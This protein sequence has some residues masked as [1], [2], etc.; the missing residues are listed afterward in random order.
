[1]TAHPKFVAYYR[2]STRAQEQSGLGLAAQQDAVERHVDMT[3]G[4]Q[5]IASHTEIE[6]G[7]NNARPKLAQALA[8]CRKAKAILVIAKLDRLARN[9]AFISG[10][11]DSDVEF[12]ACDMPLA[13]RLTI[14]VLAAVAEHERAMISERT[15]AGLAA[16]RQRGRVGGNRR[17]KNKEPEAVARTKAARAAH[18]ARQI[19][20]SLGDWLPVVTR[21]RPEQSWTEVA[22]FLNLGAPKDAR[23]WTAERLKRATA[24]AVNR[25]LVKIEVLDRAP[26][27]S[28]DE[29]LM[30]LAAAIQRSNPD[31]SLRD[32]GA[33]LRN[34]RERTPRGS[35]RWNASSVKHLL[36]RANAQ[37]AG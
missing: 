33:R 17:L 2:V 22:R 19:E 36:D 26:Q 21:L 11:M 32:I 8:E 20:A 18:Y 14:H 29:R 30:L 7:A 6:S 12:V 35:S 16:A 4:A 28:V 1:M 9:V 37:F 5:I 15:K 10:L 3:P 34:L 25:N 13:N 24:W 31:W 23:T 27:H